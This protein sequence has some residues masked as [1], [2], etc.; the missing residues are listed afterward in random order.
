[1]SVSK[2]IKYCQSNKAPLTIEFYYNGALIEN[3]KSFFGASPLLFEKDFPSVEAIIEAIGNN[4]HV[5]N[6]HKLV[7]S[8]YGF[9]L[10]KLEL[11]V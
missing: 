8:E 9:H 11:R 6:T 5:K 10:I 3:P 4:Y 1:M 2:I 7:I